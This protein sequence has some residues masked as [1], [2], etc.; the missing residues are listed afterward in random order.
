MQMLKLY[1]QIDIEKTETPG[2][3]LMPQ[4]RGHGKGQCGVGDDVLH[5][6][7]Q[8]RQLLL[9]RQLRKISQQYAAAPGE[10]SHLPV[11]VQHGLHPGK[12]AGIALQEQHPSRRVRLP[13]RSGKF[14]RAAD[15]AAADF[16]GELAAL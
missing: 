13:R 8:F 5:Y 3:R 14:Q 7:V 16:S 12:T 9:F 15:V 6:P 11:L 2:I 4:L 10:H 1:D